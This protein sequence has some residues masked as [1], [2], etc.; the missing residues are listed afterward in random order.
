MIFTM[1]STIA[2]IRFWRIRKPNGRKIRP[3][4]SDVG[5]NVFWDCNPTNAYFGEKI[6][7]SYKS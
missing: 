4:H 3:G 5:T 2:T 1:E 6:S 7:S